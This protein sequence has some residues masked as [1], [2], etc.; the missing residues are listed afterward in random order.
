MFHVMGLLIDSMGVAFE[1]WALSVNM[2]AAC[3][4]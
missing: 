4:S 1:Q 3:S 2:G